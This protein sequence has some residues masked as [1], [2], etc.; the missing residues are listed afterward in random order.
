MLPRSHGS[1]LFTRGETQAIVVVTL[2]TGVGGAIIYQNTIFRG[3][4]GGAGEIGHMTIDYDGPVA[5]SGVAGAMM[6]ASYGRPA[7]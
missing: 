1:A 5:R 7:P 4:T 3:A 2:G 6:K